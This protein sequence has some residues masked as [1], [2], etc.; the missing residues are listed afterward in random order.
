MITVDHLSKAIKGKPILSDISFTIEAGDCLALIGPN[1]AGKTTLM[2]CMLGDKIASRGTVLVDNEAPKSRAN[3]EQIAYLAQENLIPK[4]LKVKELIAFFRAIHRDSLR[5]SEIVDLLGFSPLQYHQL[6]DNLSGGQRRLLAFVLCLIGKPNY[7]FLDEPTAGMD[8]TTRQHF[9]EIIADLKKKGVTIVYSSHYIEEVEHTADRILVLNQGKLIRDTTPFAM[10]NEECEKQVT[11]SL[12]FENLVL[13]LKNVYDVKQGRDT[14]QFMTKD[15]GSVWEKL[16]QSG[17]SISD[18]EVQN[19][20][21]LNSLF[22]TTRGD[23]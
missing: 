21:L 4:G 10:R 15:L 16:Q 7:L 3:K 8:T 12:D 9:W 22:D 1:G 14:V 18:I 17:C 20:T 23:K 6:A 19:K 2:S 11:L 13:G 5:E